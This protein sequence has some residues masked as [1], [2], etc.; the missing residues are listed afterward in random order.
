MTFYKYWPILDPLWP[1]KIQTCQ[2]TDYTQFLGNIIANSMYIN[3]VSDEEIIKVVSK[4]KNKQSCYD[5]INML[6]VK[7]VIYGIV[8]PLTFICNKSFDS[9][10]FPNYMKI[11]KVIQLFKTG[12]RKECSNYIPVY[13][14]SLKV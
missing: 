6:V 12:N 3:P 1:T 8:K 4:F 13:H 10:I 11:A 2:R 14:S 5:D 9:G 7:R